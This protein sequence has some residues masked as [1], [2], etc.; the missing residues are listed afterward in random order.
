MASFSMT[1]NDLNPG[2]TVTA[3]FKGEYFKTL[4]LPNFR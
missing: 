4:H 1:L 3:L 2:F